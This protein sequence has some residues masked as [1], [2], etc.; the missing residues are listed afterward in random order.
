M[1]MDRKSKFWYI[2]SKA[3]V[4]KLNFR[5]VLEERLKVV[6]KNHLQLELSEDVKYQPHV[7]M[8]WSRYRSEM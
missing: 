5:A 2:P 6:R 8:K 7:K 4:Y 1:K 3:K